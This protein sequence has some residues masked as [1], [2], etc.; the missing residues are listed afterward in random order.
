MGFWGLE[1]D[2]PGGTHDSWREGCPMGFR[3]ARCSSGPSPSLL[4]CPQPRLHKQR[5]CVPW[6]AG[7]SHRE[8]FGE[9]SGFPQRWG[10]ATP[11]RPSDPGSHYPG[12]Q[13]TAQAWALGVLRAWPRLSASQGKVWVHTPWPEDVTLGLPP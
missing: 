5:P 6:P 8:S 4:S 13:P 11:G 7:H 9:Q 10:W 2:F 1:F 3:Q 12:K